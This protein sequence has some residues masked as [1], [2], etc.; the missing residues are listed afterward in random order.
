MFIVRRLPSCRLI[1]ARYRSSLL[2]LLR[3]RLA[4]LGS[5][6]LF[7]VRVRNRLSGYRHPQPTIMHS[8]SDYRF[9]SDCFHSTASYCLSALKSY[10]CFTIMVIWWLAFATLNV[11]VSSAVV[12]LLIIVLEVFS[13]D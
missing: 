9:Y 8:Y 10:R 13:S 1:V 2:R 6:L 3:V 12:R 4:V 5:H 7:S 11:V